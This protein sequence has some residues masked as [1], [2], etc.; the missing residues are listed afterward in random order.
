MATARRLSAA[1]RIVHSCRQLDEAQSDGR[2]ARQLQIRRAAADGEVDAPGQ[3]M[4]E[5]VARG[6]LGSG[7]RGRWKEAVARG[8]IEEELPAERTEHAPARAGGAFL[9]V[10]A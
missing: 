6:Q 9:R 7:Q 5:V 3:L 1:E 10:V 4:A 8:L 2:D